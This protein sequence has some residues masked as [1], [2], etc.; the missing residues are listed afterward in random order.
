VTG[1]CAYGTVRKSILSDRGNSSLRHRVCEDRVLAADTL[2]VVRKSEM[3]LARA[4]AALQVRSRGEF[5]SA[6]FRLP[7]KEASSKVC[8]PA[9]ATTQYSLMY[10]MFK[11]LRAPE[12]REPRALL[13]PLY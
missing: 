3:K 5:L 12:F 4:N 13:S 2:I 1:I 8:P 6:A 10:S 11:V 7:S 9:I